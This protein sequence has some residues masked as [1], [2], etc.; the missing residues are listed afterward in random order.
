MGSS[1]LSP[2]VCP[3]NGAI[4]AVAFAFL[5]AWPNRESHAT[6]DAEAAAAEADRLRER[7]DSLGATLKMASGASAHWRQFLFDHYGA[8]ERQYHTLRHLSELF[9]HLD[10]ATANGWLTRPENVALAIWFHDVIYHGKNGEDEEASALAFER[11]G[12][13][14]GLDASDI[15]SVASWIRLTATHKCSEAEHGTDCCLFMDFDMAILGKRWDR[16]WEGCPVA[17]HTGYKDYALR[18]VLGEYRRLKGVPKVPL[19]ATCCPPDGLSDGLP[20]GL[21]DT[22]SPDGISEIK[23]AALMAPLIRTLMAPSSGLRA[24]LRALGLELWAST[25]LTGRQGSLQYLGVQR[26]VR[27]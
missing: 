23:I 26:T 21:P 20:D 1:F 11:F 16:T 9:W 4:L 5:L 10:R 24:S 25:L 6:A 7:W 15:A 14:A 3:G 22:K 2:A 27:G 18:D 12:K 13:E 17:P 8:D 19:C